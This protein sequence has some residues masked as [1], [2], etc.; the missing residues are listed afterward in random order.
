VGA[1]AG[2]WAVGYSPLLRQVDQ[3]G[4]DLLCLTYTSAPLEDDLEI[5]GTPEAELYLAFDS[6]DDAD[7]VVRL[8]DV[9]P[10]DTSCNITTGWLKASRYRS[11]SHP[12]QLHPGQV[13][14]MRIRLSPT[15]YVVPEGHRLRVS[16]SCADFPYVLPT[17]SKPNIR[18]H[19]GGGHASR[20]AIPVVP[21]AVAPLPPPVI[22]RLEPGVSLP[23]TPAPPIWKVERDFVSGTVSVKSG[24]CLT[25]MLPNAATLRIERVVTAV[26]NDS[27]PESARLDTKTVMDIRQPNGKFIQVEATALITEKTNLLNGKVTIDGHPIFEKRWS[28]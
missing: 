27:R 9:D 12:E 26:V 5:T 20:V 23:I 14:E 7:L 3:A 28:R 1:E 4:E 2:S 22:P 11:H 25:Y 6:G 24:T 10:A 13:Y 19:C 16:L 21:A 15:S 18:L 17:A 8:N